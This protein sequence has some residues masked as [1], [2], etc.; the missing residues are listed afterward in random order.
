MKSSKYEHS[1]KL[2]EIHMKH[3]GSIQL[4]G[5]RPNQP[6]IKVRLPGN[7]YPNFYEYLKEIESYCILHK[8][9]YEILPSSY[10]YES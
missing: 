8:L 3:Y 5:R 9:K 2:F 7:K 1:N 10:M 6:L 4:K